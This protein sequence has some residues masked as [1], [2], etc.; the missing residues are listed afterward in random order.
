M[1]N[2]ITTHVPS[3]TISGSKH[4]PKPW[5]TSEIR[6][7]LKKR[8]T[9]YGVWLKTKQETNLTSYLEY[10]SKAQKLIRQEH[11]KYTESLLNIVQTSVD[12]P[13]QKPDTSKTF[14]SYIKS[15]RKDFCS[16]PPLKKEGVLIS[17]SKGKADI[18]NEQYSSCTCL[19]IS[20]RSEI[21]ERIEIL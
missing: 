11:W 14:R 19:R 10:K 12:N 4:A 16:V 13:R 7:L 2:L 3:K 15:K 1:H 21:Q 20:M 5:I 6:H 17:D 8:D 9:L 18:L